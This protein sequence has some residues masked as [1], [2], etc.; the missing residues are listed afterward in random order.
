[1]GKGD[2]ILGTTRKYLSMLGIREPRMPTD[3]WM[4]LGVL[5]GE[6]FG[7]HRRYNKERT[8]WYITRATGGMRPEVDAHFMALKNRVKKPS[9]KDRTM[10]SLLISKT[11]WR[12]TD[13]RAALGRKCISN[14]G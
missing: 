1:M 4:V 6:G 11:P 8:T 7:V 14:Q 9:R 2:Y 10:L 12:L 13:Q 5:T 3:H